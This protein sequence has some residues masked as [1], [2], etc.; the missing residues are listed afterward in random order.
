MK[1]LRAFFSKLTGLFPNA[2]RERELA[3]ELE[4]HLQMHIDD[5]LRAGMSPS[6]ARREAIMKLGGVEPTKQ[7]YREAR[8]VPFVENALR[9]VRFAIRQLR[10]NPGFTATAVFILALGM[11]A[12]VAI[13]AFV[14]AALIKPLP[15]KNPGRLVAVFESIPLFHHSNLSYLDYLD[16]KKMN[17]SFVSLEVYQHTGMMLT[18]AE[19]GKAARGALVSDGFFRALGVTPILGRDFYPGEDL[20]AAPRTLLLSFRTWQDQYGGK[21]EVLGRTV[22][23][24]GEAHVIVGVLPGGF[25]FAPAEPADY[26]VSLHAIGECAERRSCHNLL[27]LARLRDGVS[28]EAALA[29]VKRVAQQLEK[30]YPDSNRDQSASLTTLTA[31]TVGT[32]RPILLALMGGAGLL[33]LIAT[34]NVASLLLV[35]SESRRR[36]MSVRSA[37]GASSGRLVGQFVIE[38][39]VL[40]SAGTALGLV[41]ASGAMQLLSKLIPADMM[42]G[43]PYL[44]DL[45]FNP[46]VLAFAGLIALLAALMFSLTPT[47][48]F[49]LS[50]MREGIAEGSRGSSGRNWGRVGSK[51]VVLELATAMVL[52]VGAGLLGKSLYQ[53]LHV[54]L[55]F[56][57]DHLVTMEVAA[58][59]AYDNDKKVIALERLIVSKIESLPGVKSVDIASTLPI[60]HWGNTTWVRVLGRPWHGEHLEMP[61]REVSARYFKTVGAKLARGRFFNEGE[62]ASKPHVVMINQAFVKQYFPGEDPLGKQLTYLTTK[63]EPMEIV[64][65][66]EDVKEG[67]LDTESHPVLYLHFDQDPSS[68]FNLVVRTSQAEEPLIPLLASTIRDIDRGIVADKGA[69]MTA[70]I[71]D[72]YSAYL[73]RSSAWLVGGFAALALLLGVVGLY[74]VV[75]YS[76]SQRT[77]EI[78][79][80]M[81]LGA[82]RVSVY[83]LVLKEAGWLT[84]AGIVIG[85]GCSIGGAVLIRSLLFGVKSWDVPTLI[86]VALVLSVASLLASYIP[87]RRAASVN[88]VEALRAE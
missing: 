42:A 33:L 13:F 53:L 84:A 79:V 16:W 18:T 76:V 61:A 57:A 77:R 7:V 47:L 44:R 37:L 82:D 10:K 63:P 81:A 35:R 21:A 2:R 80:R 24:N 72:S 88:P 50:K 9:D 41:A 78:G 15:Y 20:P 36:E 34:V 65:I 83:Q 23:V 38:G 71:N 29:D 27:G 54:Q 4:G 28:F 60:S 11:C 26:W 5:N 8:S 45:G 73:H 52:L 40:V 31:E 86:G 1:S 69:T 56:E 12:S 75:A 66:I 62:D 49:S 58:P 19:G 17:K 30:Q 46:R 67:A 43:M 87:A 85:V 68:D 55:G 3:D 51:L 70:R 6:D 48:H 32:V 25:H 39:L 22:V 14:D 59:K 74:G 64:G